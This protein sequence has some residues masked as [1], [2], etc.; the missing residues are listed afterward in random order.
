[1]LFPSGGEHGH[2][3]GGFKP[4]ANVPAEEFVNKTRG[5]VRSFFKLPLA[6]KLVNYFLVRK[7]SMLRKSSHV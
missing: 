7:P 2:L 4:P 1:V 5:L 6:Q 3:V